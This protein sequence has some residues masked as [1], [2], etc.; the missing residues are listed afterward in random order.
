[1]MWSIVVERSISGRTW[2]VVGVATGD[3]KPETREILEGGFFAHAVA[4]GCR[5]WWEQQCLQAEAEQAERKAGW[6]PNP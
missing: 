2:N 4:E 3:G 6:D 1:M 5:Q